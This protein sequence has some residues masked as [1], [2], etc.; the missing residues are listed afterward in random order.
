MAVLTIIAMSDGQGNTNFLSEDHALN[1]AL[2]RDLSTELMAAQVFPAAVSGQTGVLPMPAEASAGTVTGVTA[3]SMP[4]QGQTMLQT[5]MQ[6]NL[7]GVEQTVAPMSSA[8]LA[9]TMTNNGLP[10]LSAIAVPVSQQQQQQV[11][12][13]RAMSAQSIGS[14]QNYMEVVG[15]STFLSA[16]KL[17]GNTQQQSLPEV[18]GQALPPTKQAVQSTMA[19]QQ[20]QSQPTAANALASEHKISSQTQTD[21]NAASVE[22]QQPVIA[23]VSPVHAEAAEQPV[24]AAQTLVAAVHNPPASASYQAAM[25]ARQTATMMPGTAPQARS[26]T[27][28]AISAQ[29]QA[30][31]HPL[32]A[33]LQQPALPSPTQKLGV[34]NEAPSQASTAGPYIQYGSAT[35]M[36]PMAPPVQGAPY[37]TQAYAQAPTVQSAYPQ[38]SQLPAGQMPAPPGQYSPQPAQTQAYPANSQPAQRPQANLQQQPPYQ[39]AQMPQQQQQQQPVAQAYQPSQAF[40]AASQPGY[41]AS[42]QASPQAYQPAAQQPQAH[43]QPQYQAGPQPPAQTFQPQAPNVAAP[44]PNSNGQTFGANAAPQRGSSQ[45]SAAT[46]GP[47]GA[48]GAR[49][50]LGHRDDPQAFDKGVP[51]VAAQVKRT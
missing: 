2:R 12:T 39:P 47:V 13:V 30:Q 35:Q 3:T 10:V 5:A 14:A 20:P 49:P 7:Q 44:L 34:A 40:A 6:P 27:P 32:S 50:D 46:Q 43:S 41:Q 9:Q 29:A 8:Q 18:I 11:P 28:Q 4:Q 48:L 31:A 19:Y 45:Q 1:T 23:A 26:Q 17:H 22:V 38:P 15:Q 25:P 24:V 33:Q 21:R 16:S 37:S 51:I 36:M 42:P